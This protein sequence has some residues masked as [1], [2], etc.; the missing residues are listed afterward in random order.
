M[1]P[2]SKKN[3][4]AIV[5]SKLG[6]R[7]YMVISIVMTAARLEICQ[8]NRIRESAI[9]IGACSETAQRMPSIEAAIKGKSIEEALGAIS[10]EHIASL[11]P[12][13]IR[14]P[15]EYRF[16]AAQQLIKRTLINCQKIEDNM[17]T[18]FRLNNQVKLHCDPQRD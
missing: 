16:Y 13:D 12:L 1:H 4:L 7:E 18:S 14:A 9:A 8:Q 15:R 10:S 17:Q 3:A 6:A 11:D 2:C 5:L